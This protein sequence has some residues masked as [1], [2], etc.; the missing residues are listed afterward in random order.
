MNIMY[1]S[2]QLVEWVGAEEWILVC[3][4]VTLHVLCVY[5]SMYP[6]LIYLN[7]EEIPSWL[8]CGSC[9][10]C[11]LPGVRVTARLGFFF[12]VQVV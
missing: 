4:N 7:A 5:V 12:Y 2:S 11:M 1:T 10:D 8:V 6:S 3:V 9:L